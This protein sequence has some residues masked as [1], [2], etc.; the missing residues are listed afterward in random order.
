MRYVFILPLIAG[1]AAGCASPEPEL[2]PAD[3]LL[4]NG[5]VYT[6]S[7]GEPAPDGTPAA[8]APHSAEGW[9]PDAQAVAIRDGRLVFVG[10]AADAE[11]YRG[12]GTRVMDVAGATILPGLVD[13]HT[14]VVG[15]GQLEV[16]VNLIG[17]AT[18]QEAIERVAAASQD[19][20]AGEWILARGWDEGAWA[21]RYPTW[22]QLSERFPDNPVVMNSLHGFAVWG[23]KRAFEEAGI[24]KETPAPTG[25]EIRKDPEGN[26]TGILLNRA[27]GLLMGPSPSRRT[28]STRAGCSRGSSA[29]RR[30]ATS[31]CT[32]RASTDGS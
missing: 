16:Q 5:R 9:A 8:G 23:N 25:G 2:E 20:A 12:D 15:L 19:V 3:V 28:R 26:L 10:S 31:R 4:T 6:L 21:T 32:R 29:W 17:V 7:W 18:E 14:H 24:T 11:A 27:G 13:S 1:L 22:D 30:T